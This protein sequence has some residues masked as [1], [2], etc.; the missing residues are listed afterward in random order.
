MKGYM[1][2]IALVDLSTQ[3]VFDYFVSDKDRKLFLG[4]KSLAAKIIYDNI[5]GKI[6]P[7]SAENLVVITTSPLTGSTA[8]CSSRF[9]V[10]TI[11]P[12]TGLLTSSNCGGNFG[13][14]LKKAG[15]DGLVIKGKAQSPVLLEVTNDTI[16]FK[17]AL[18]LWG[19]KTGETEQLIGGK[20]NG[21]FV[22]GPAGE[23]LVLYAG[24]F[25]NER[26]AGRGGVGAVFGSKNLKGLV[27]EGTNSFAFYDKEKF[28]KLNKKWIS[29]LKK[30]PLTGGQLPTYGTAGLVTP[31][32][33]RNLLATK[34][35]KYGSYDKFEDISGETLT[36]KHLVKNKGCMSCPIHCARVVTVHGKQVK[37]PEVETITLFGSNMLNNNMKA[38]LHINH[39]ADEY[40]LDTISMGSTIA[41][42]MELNEKGLWNS[43]LSFGDM[44]NIEKTIED[45]AYR[46]GNGDLLADGSKRLAEKFGGKEYA[47]NVKGMEL[48]A[49][50]PRGAQGMGL[51]YA[52]ANR[53]GCH[54]NGGYMVVLEGLGLDISG[55][56]TKGKAAFS[57][58]FQDLMEAVS[59]G[60]SC[61][62]TTYAVLP[63]Y[64]I[65]NP[66]AFISKTV[67][68]VAPFFGGVI[69][70]A[71][72]FPWILSLNI[73]AM[74]PHSAMINHLTGM[75]M[76]IGSLK[77]TGERGYN[78]ERVINL[79]LGMTGEQDKLPKRLIK[80]LQRQ[81]DKSSVV[82]LSEMLPQYYSIRGWDKNGVPTQKTLKKLGIE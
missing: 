33:F 56:T 18:N 36:E 21:K 68:K 34:N 24:V 82:K 5:K 15:F 70:L 7:F 62:F 48:A 46:R 51:S 6:D 42:A 26:A 43:G 1:N 71:H 49:Y 73:P 66:N 32:N 9:N 4:G 29:I 23:N 19:K 2:K 28:K 20:N 65:S 10:S 76:T 40:G 61:L 13:I 78:L 37:G 17:D 54:L 27:A 41:F 38:I 59:S 75:K 50:E 45:I 80:D 31:M 16:T 67:N 60:G 72:K 25:S 47:I 81:D 77:K 74:I 63:G 58:F 53:G 22:I 35:Y 8:P 64:L 52:T 14:F 57:I 30:H 3:L 79:R 12:L 39:L 55:K 44:T 11:S 69:A